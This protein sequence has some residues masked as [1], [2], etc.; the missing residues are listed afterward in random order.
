[1]CSGCNLRARSSRAVASS[2]FLST[3]CL[4]MQLTLLISLLQS[5]HDFPLLLSASTL[6]RA[7][8]RNIYSSHS[9]GCRLAAQLP[10]AVVVQGLALAPLSVV[11][12]DAGHPTVLAVSP[13]LSVRADAAAPAVHALTLASAES[14]KI[15][16]NSDARIPTDSPGLNRNA[17]RAFGLGRGVKNMQQL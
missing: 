3:R 13:T 7:R 15:G 10:F 14:S 9:D 11:L 17:L 5:T 2:R 1:L 12:T 16:N 4:S 8:S 6:L